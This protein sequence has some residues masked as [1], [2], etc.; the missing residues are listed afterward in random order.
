MA[1]EGDGNNRSRGKDGVGDMR[2]SLNRSG[3]V[4]GEHIARVKII[5]DGPSDR[6]ARLL[7]Y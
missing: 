6:L 2:L 5:F 1:V 4:G 3:S 7:R